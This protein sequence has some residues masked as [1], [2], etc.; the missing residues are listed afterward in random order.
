MPSTTDATYP[1]S[2]Y[3]V[4]S[5]FWAA[6]CAA[7]GTDLRG[8]SLVN[9]DVFGPVPDGFVAKLRSKLRPAGI[10]YGFGQAGFGQSRGIA[11]AHTDPPVLPHEPLGQPMEEMRAAVL[12]LGV[13]GP[14][15]SP[16]S[17]ALS[18]T[19]RL[20]VFSVNAWSFNLLATGQRRQG[21]QAKVDAYLADPMLPVFRDGDLQIEVPATAG[22]LS[23][24]AAAN[25]PGDGTAE[26][27]RV[28]PTEKDR[29]A[30][31]NLNRAGRLEGDPPQRLPAAPSRALAVLISR[32]GELLADC[33][34]GI[35]VKAQKLTAAGGESDQIEAGRPGFVVPASCFLDLPAV[36]PDT[37]HSPRPLLQMPTGRRILDPVSV[38]Q[39]HGNMINNGCWKDKVDA[40]HLADILTLSLPSAVSELRT[41]FEVMR[42][43]TVRR[44]GSRR[45]SRTCVSRHLSA[46]A[47]CFE[48]D[49][50]LAVGVACGVETF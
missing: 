18:E 39:H 34:H 5:T 32:N 36:V 31:F 7:R 26:P 29:H 12:D 13:D 35:E 44:D 46:T 49:P 45:W 43:V 48:E 27:Q 23:E 24:A 47:E 8:Q 3:E 50:L 4:F 1:L 41:M 30:T 37:I 16:A 17:G 40:K 25:L 33:L 6:A 28:P 21:L 9:L 22:I 14:R 42:P 11:V 2:H 15:A 19:E 38:C 20:L 10:E